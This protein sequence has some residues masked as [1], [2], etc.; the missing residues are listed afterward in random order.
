LTE[1][2][3]L[4]RTYNP[5]SC[6]GSPQQK[7]MHHRKPVEILFS[8]NLRWDFVP[9]LCVNASTGP[10]HVQV[11]C[12]FKA[13]GVPMKHVGATY[14]EK[15]NLARGLV[16]IHS[17]KGPRFSCHIPVP[18]SYYFSVCA[19]ECCARCHSGS[20]LCQHEKD[21]GRIVDNAHQLTKTFM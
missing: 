19:N 3:R 13:W 2:L 10:A 20:L 7:S 11:G 4:H 14:F 9:G 12:S 1:T 16:D 8:T 15:S 18:P 6:G 21:T 17:N 5:I